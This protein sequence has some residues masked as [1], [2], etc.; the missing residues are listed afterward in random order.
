MTDD[1]LRAIQELVESGN[2]EAASQHLQNL[3]SP[4]P[5]VDQA[6]TLAQLYWQLGYAE[7][8]GRLWY[9]TDS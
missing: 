2:F 3:I 8:A 4:Y 5:T 7:M 9:L 6:D 1:D